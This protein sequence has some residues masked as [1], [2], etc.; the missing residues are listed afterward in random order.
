MSKSEVEHTF[1]CTDELSTQQYLDVSKAIQADHAFGSMMDGGKSIKYID[2]YAAI[3]DTRDSSIFNIRIDVR[4]F[5]KIRFAL[6]PGEFMGHAPKFDKKKETITGKSMFDSI[7]DYLGETE[8]E[9]LGHK[10]FHLRTIECM[11]GKYTGSKVPTTGALMS[12]IIDHG[13]DYKTT[14]VGRAKAGD[15]TTAFF[16]FDEPTGKLAVLDT[17]KD[18]RKRKTLFNGKITTFDDFQRVLHLCGVE[19]KW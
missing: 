19:L 11:Y 13:F 3:Q 18:Q 8:G 15:V 5:A 16:L 9:P 4:G 12:A 14:H 10:I 2:G 7:M 1:F 6:V 17:N